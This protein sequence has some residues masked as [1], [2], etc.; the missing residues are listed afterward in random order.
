[1]DARNLD[2]GILAWV[3]RIRPEESTY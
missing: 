3:A 1:V 2:G